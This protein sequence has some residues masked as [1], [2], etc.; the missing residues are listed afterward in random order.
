MYVQTATSSTIFRA[1]LKDEDG[2]SIMDWGFQTGSLRDGGFAV[3]VL[4]RHTFQITNASQT[5]TFKIKLR[6]EE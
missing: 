2:D 4:G 5:D 6:V 3:P 1:N